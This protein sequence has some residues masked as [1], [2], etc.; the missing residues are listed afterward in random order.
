MAK[1]RKGFYWVYG[2]V[3]AGYAWQVA[4]WN[5]FEWFI[6]GDAWSYED[7]DLRRIGERIKHG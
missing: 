1:R 4:Y 7:D 5:D 3:G 2:R 6:T